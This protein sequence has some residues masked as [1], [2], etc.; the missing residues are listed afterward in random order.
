MKLHNRLTGLA[1]AAGLGLTATP[2]AHAAPTP[3]PPAN[4]RA[5]Y[6]LGGD[7]T[8]AS[9]VT[10][11]VRDWFEG[12]PLANPNSYSICYVN[13]FQTQPDSG[14]GRRDET[15]QWPASIV[16]RNFQDPNWPGEYL[17]DIR[18]A[19]KRTIA[20]NHL[21]PMI[22]TCASKGF[23]AVEFDNLDSYTRFSGLPFRFAQTVSFAKLITTYA[24][25][26][27]LAVAQKNT[28]ELTKYQA[29]TVIKFDFVISENCGQYDECGDYAAVYGDRMIDIEYT[30]EGFE[31]ACATVG[32]TVS[33]I[34]RDID[35]TTPS[36][37]EYDYAAC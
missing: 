34:R 3:P 29:R 1:L 25:S 5:D 8:P 10:V 36:S 7:Y 15:S 6:Q 30:Q 24:H 19:A 32:A 14:S 37:S 22:D 12:T 21:K 26:K 2:T 35:L 28:A 11:V 13:A 16:L 31:Q 27:G 23:K 20:L 9:G 17:I 18:S 4:A 33:V